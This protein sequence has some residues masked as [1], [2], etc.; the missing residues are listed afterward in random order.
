MEATRAPTGFAVKVDDIVIFPMVINAAVV[1]LAVV[2]TGRESK[3]AL[4]L[5]R[6]KM[7]FFFEFSLPVS[8]EE[9][10]SFL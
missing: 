2:F 1:G 4:I 9:S 7:N 8:L 6:E 10:I 3:L 5:S